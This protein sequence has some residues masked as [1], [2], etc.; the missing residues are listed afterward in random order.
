M[1]V[2]DVKGEHYINVHARAHVYVLIRLSVHILHTLDR[3]A[4]PA[5]AAPQ[6]TQ[7]CLS[8]RR[9][10]RLTFKANELSAL[11]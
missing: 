5:R 4:L 9:K 10:I 7:F 3:R 6:D 2:K 11:E 1:T 8:S